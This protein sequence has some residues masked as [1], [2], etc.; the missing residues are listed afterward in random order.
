MRQGETWDTSKRRKS[1]RARTFRPGLYLPRN[2]AWCSRARA[3]PRRP[4]PAGPWSVRVRSAPRNVRPQ[5][6][7][8]AS[9][10]HALTLVS[11]EFGTATRVVGATARIVP[12]T[13]SAGKR[14][15]TIT[16]RSRTM[17]GWRGSGSMASACAPS[18]VSARGPA[19]RQTRLPC[20]RPRAARRSGR[21]SQSHR[22]RS[23]HRASTRQPAPAAAHEA[24]TSSASSCRA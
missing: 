13:C 20:G 18:R 15:S 11:I 16:D 2:V 17:D 6:Q 23:S 24:R 1:G 19:H 3:R 5:R 9:V 12:R 10:R 8:H 22:P 7:A 14:S 4:P 21:S